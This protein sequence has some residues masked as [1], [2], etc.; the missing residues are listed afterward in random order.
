MQERLLEYMGSWNITK[1]ILSLQP[2]QTI[3]DRI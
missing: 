1:A 2:N 3:T